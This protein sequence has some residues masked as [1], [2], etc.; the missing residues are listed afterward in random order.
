MTRHLSHELQPDADWD[1]MLLHYLGLDHIG[2]IA[3]PLSPLVGPKLNEMDEV[4]R[5]IYDF[6]VEKVGVKPICVLL[7]FLRNSR[8]HEIDVIGKIYFLTSF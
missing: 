4:V 3:T 7:Q 6:L 5:R 1:V 2:H 8:F